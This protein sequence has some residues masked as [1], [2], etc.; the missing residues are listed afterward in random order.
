M[1]ELGVSCVLPPKG[2]STVAAPMVESKRSERP[3]LEATL[4]SVTSEVMR[5]ASVVPASW[6]PHATGAHVGDLVL[7]CAVGV[8]ELAGQV[9][10]SDAVPGHAHA[11]LSGNLGDNGRLQVL[12][13]GVAHELLD[14]TVGDGAG[15]ALLGL[16]DSELGAVQAVVLLGH[17]VQVDIQAV[18]KLA[19]GDR[20][21]AGAKVVAALDQTAGVAA[22]EQT[23]QLALDRGVALL[24]LGTRG[25]DGLGVLGLGGAG[26]ATDAIAAGAA[27]Q[28]DDLV[29]GGGALAT[30]V[31]CR[32]SAHDGA[33]LH[34]LG[35]VTG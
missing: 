5:S 19:H 34:A 33:N 26:G 13:G 11:R 24:D 17:G 20:D 23:L 22:A 9:D 25:L 16:R 28:Q 32:G 18:G 29:G 8:E 31:V 6:L 30:N 4:R 1:A 2:M 15:H 7:G 27:A 10:D 21:A 14:V 12:L 35:H 3:L